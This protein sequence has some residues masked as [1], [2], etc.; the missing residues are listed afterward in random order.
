MS[1]PC[2]Q[3]EAQVVSV[4]KHRERL[5]CSGQSRVCLTCTVEIV[6]KCQESLK[7]RKGPI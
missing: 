1:D 5:L 3:R 2:C 7:V 6:G 4:L